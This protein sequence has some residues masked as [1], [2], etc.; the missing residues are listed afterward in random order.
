[1]AAIRGHD[2][3]LQ[4]VQK[5]MT[6]ATLPLVRLADSFLLAESDSAEV[7]APTDAL[8][9]CLSSFSLPVQLQLAV[10]CELADGPTAQGLL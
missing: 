4:S 5:V 8:H 10:Y 9:A 1:M 3:Q 7:P 2:L 6:K